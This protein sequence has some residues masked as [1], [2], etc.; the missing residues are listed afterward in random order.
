M[1]NEI[2]G[3]SSAVIPLYGG[4]DLCV[5]EQLDRNVEAPLSATSPTL[6][7]TPSGSR[8]SNALCSDPLTGDVDSEHLRGAAPHELPAEEAGAGGQIE[9]RLAAHVPWPWPP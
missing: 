2:G 1:T 4:N 8:S 3:S 7:R 9:D 5:V 6:S